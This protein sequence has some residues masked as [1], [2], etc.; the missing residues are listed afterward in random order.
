LNRQITG[1]VARWHFAPTERAR[2]NLLA[3]GV[4][5]SQI[6]VTGN[7][8]VDALN[9]TNKRLESDDALRDQISASLNISIGLASIE[10]PLV[11]ITSHRR[12]NFDGGLFRI[13]KAIGILASAHPQVTFV[14][15]LHP[16]PSVMSMVQTQLSGLEN[17]RLVHALP[18]LDFVLLMNRSLFILTDSGGIQEEALVLKKPVLVLRD[19]TE[20]SEGLTTGGAML[21]GSRTEEI[22]VEATKLLENQST[23]VIQ[24][25]DR[26]A[27]G[28]G[29]AA[30][31]IIREL[32]R[33]PDITN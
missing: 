9:L 7:T 17:V 22:V 2:Q 19:K 31:R 8:V 18:Y 14:Y 28:D 30:E 4:S 12:E 21:V 27:Y 15:T 11:L 23:L 25:S 33:H 3:E 6:W 26:W 5:D 20:R 32:M 10:N 29:F 24:E 13:C 16:N 1:K